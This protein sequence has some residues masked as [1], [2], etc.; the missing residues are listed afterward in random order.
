MRYN[1][2]VRHNLIFGVP[3]TDDFFSIV[4]K[5]K[6]VHIH[7]QLFPE[8]K[9]PLQRWLLLLV[10]EPVSQSTLVGAHGTQHSDAEVRARSSRG[11]DLVQHFVCRLE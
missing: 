4:S 10:P 3:E 7:Q 2:A 6:S 8:P 1:N 9:V 5:Y 11:M